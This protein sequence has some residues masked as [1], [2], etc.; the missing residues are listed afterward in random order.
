MTM[1]HFAAAALAPLISFADVTLANG[2]R[3]HYAQQGPATGPAIILLH[4]YSDSSFSFSRVM[5]LLPPGLRIIAPDLRGHGESDRPASGYRID[6]MASDVLLLM[7]ALGIPTAAIVGHSMGSFVAQSVAARAPQ[8]LS[9]MVLVGSAPVIDNDVVRGLRETIASLTD[10]VDGEFVRS[11]Q[12]G[13]IALPVPGEFMNA[14]IDNSRRMPARVWKEVFDGF[15]AYRPPAHPPAVRALVM[16][17]KKDAVFSAAEQAEL[18][19]MLPGARLQLFDEVGHAPHW[20]QPHV[21]VS[22]LMSVIE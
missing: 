18:A 1:V 12:Y 22:A 13:T 4:G 8:R 9:A 11:F 5:P 7:D 6:D 2:V 15:L 21:F 3:L 17:G 16:G 20:E 19:R 14:A 10:P